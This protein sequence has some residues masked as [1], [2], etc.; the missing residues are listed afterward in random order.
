MKKINENTKV[1]LTFDQLK[2]LVSESPER[3]SVAP[4]ITPRKAKAEIQRFFD[5]L[6]EQNMDGWD[7]VQDCLSM[8]TPEQLVKAYEYWAVDEIMSMGEED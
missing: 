7:Y 4:A 2:K 6:Q 1:T 5:I 8:F 3:R